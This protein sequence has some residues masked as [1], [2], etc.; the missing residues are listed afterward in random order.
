MG[1][2]DSKRPCA[3]SRYES[4]GQTVSLMIVSSDCETTAKRPVGFVITADCSD[5]LE[6]STPLQENSL[7]NTSFV[8]TTG[9]LVSHH[10]CQLI[11]QN[12]TIFMHIQTP[13]SLAHLIK[14]LPLFINHAYSTYS[15]QGKLRCIHTVHAQYI[16]KYTLTHMQ[17]LKSSTH[18]DT[19]TRSITQPDKQMESEPNGFSL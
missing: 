4:V 5:R 1:T 12:C 11:L 16:C 10:F 15:E 13:H 3:H 9:I 19:L 17:D 2:V 14:N 7:I 18:S 6:S 8:L